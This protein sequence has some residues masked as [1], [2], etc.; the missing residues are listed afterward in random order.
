M[1]WFWAN[2]VEHRSLSILTLALPLFFWL[3]L[4]EPKGQ[5]RAK[6]RV[7][8]PGSAAGS[9]C[10][11]RPDAGPLLRRPTA[12][13]QFRVCAKRAKSDVKSNNI[14]FVACNPLSFPFCMF[15]KYSRLRMTNDYFTVSSIQA[16]STSLQVS[17]APLFKPKANP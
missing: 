4:K 6:T 10:R 9:S 5:D 1:K 8:E 17:T 3:D 13:L 2:P 16:N 7:F 12:P 11:T 15:A 14:G